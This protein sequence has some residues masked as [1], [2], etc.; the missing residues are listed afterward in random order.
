MP[1]LWIVELRTPPVASIAVGT[2]IIAMRKMSLING[3]TNTRTSPATQSRST[4]N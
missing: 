3:G 2:N 1:Q 4:A